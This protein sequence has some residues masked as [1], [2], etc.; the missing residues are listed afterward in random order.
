MRKTHI[1][2]NCC[3]IIVLIA[4]LALAAVGAMVIAGRWS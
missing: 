4:L 3:G 2:V 1:K